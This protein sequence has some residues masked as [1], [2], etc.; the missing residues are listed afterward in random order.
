MDLGDGRGDGD[1]LDGRFRIVT[2]HR[3]PFGVSWWRDGTM[4][5]N[6]RTPLL[7]L[8]ALCFRLGVIGIGPGMN[9][10]FFPFFAC[11]RFH[12]TMR[13]ATSTATQTKTARDTFAERP[14]A[15]KVNMQT[16]NCVGGS[17]K[18]LSLLLGWLE[19]GR[20]AVVF[21]VLSE[22]NC[23]P[24]K[25][26]MHFF[27]ALTAQDCEKNAIAILVEH[28]KLKKMLTKKRKEDGMSMRLA[29]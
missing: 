16:C 3:P 1:V 26:T 17:A 24:V 15:V 21:N 14:S 23:W 28:R 29:Q 18:E 5:G 27:C 22:C 11:N 10:L 7:T 20:V 13:F 9:L 8:A 12:T 2:G 19:L 4:T 25:G 6:W